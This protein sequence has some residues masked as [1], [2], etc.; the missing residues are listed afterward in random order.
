MEQLV[1]YAENYSNYS[2]IEIGEED[3]IYPSL[4]II[5]NLIQYI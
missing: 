1:S 5:Y 4:D 2:S 3:K